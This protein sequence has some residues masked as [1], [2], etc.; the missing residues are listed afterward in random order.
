MY[1]NKLNIS[2]RFAYDLEVQE[3]LPNCGAQGKHWN[4][5]GHP[6]WLTGY[7]TRRLLLEETGLSE[8]KHGRQ[9]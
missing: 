2:L 8:G 6:S 4:L 5:I 3:I 9:N 1:F 7:C